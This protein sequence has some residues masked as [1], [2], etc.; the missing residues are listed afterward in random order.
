MS[1]SLDTKKSEF[2]NDDLIKIYEL[3][4]KGDTDA[5]RRYLK[6]VLKLSDDEIDEILIELK[7]E[8]RAKLVKRLKRIRGNKSF[9][10]DMSLGHKGTQA[11]E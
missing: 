4:F 5:L 3:Y 8:N 7:K 11:G 6:D 10:V 1:I 2:S 9:P